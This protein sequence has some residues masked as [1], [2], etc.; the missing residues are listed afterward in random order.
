MNDKYMREALK[1]ANKALEM[2]EVPVGTVIVKD[3]VI[4]GRGYNQRDKKKQLLKHAELIA[5]EQANKKLGDWRLNDCDMYTTN[6]PCLMCAGAIQQARI[7]TVYIGSL[8]TNNEIHKM[9]KK[10]LSN[11]GLNHKA[12]L[13]YGVLQN[14]C[15]IIMQNF[16]KNIRNK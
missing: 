1:C 10:I 16:L 6:E 3:N 9:S 13:V 5:I 2:N 4:V 14:E 12:N 11:N 8:S 7:R 15:S